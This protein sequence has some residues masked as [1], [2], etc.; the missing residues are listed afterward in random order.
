MTSTR[1][2]GNG[3]AVKWA[4]FVIKYRWLVLL[5]SIVLA[6]GMGSGG[7]KIEFDSDYHVFFGPDNPQMLTFDALQDKYTKD[8][9]VFIVFEPTDGTV[10]TQATLGAIEEFVDSSWMTPFSTR[11]DAI[12]NFQHTRA[13]EDDLYVDD[14]V[15]DAETL[16]QSRLD[17]VR[18]I[19]IHE[20]LLK[21]RLISKDGSVTAVNITVKLPGEEITE[22]AD[23]IAFVRDQIAKFE[24][25][26]PGINTYES[27]MIMMSGAFFESSQKDLST[28]IPLMFLVIILTILLLTRNISATFSTVV[29]IF[30]SIIAAM[31]MAGWLGIRL[32]PPSAS[33]PTIITTLAVADSIH[34]LITMLQ[35]MR[36]GMDK[37]S[38]I[39]ESMRLNF[40][41]VFI[42]SFTTIIGFLTMNFSD[43]PPFGDLG[44][45]TSIGMA[46]AF[47]FS[48]TILPAL[49]TI[50]PVRVKVRNGAAEE[51]R[52]IYD[53]L[54]DWVIL[55]NKKVMWGT[56]IAILGISA[57]TLRNDLNDE[58]L[59]YFDKS[60][61]F[62]SDT[63]F[64]SENL[65]GI[66][67]VEYSLAAAES[68]GINEP[69]YLADLQ[70][71]EQW[72]YE[73]PEVI[74]VNSFVE[75]AR[76][77]NKSM[78]GDSLKYYTPPA[79]R[80]EAAQYLL[81]YEMSLPFG[82][83]L[84]NQIN[85]DKSETRLTTTI[86]NVSSS[87]LIAFKER[88]ENWLKAN[89]PSH[90]HTEGTSTTVVFSYLT[91][92]Q[93]NSMM[94][95]SLL[96][97][98]L[99]SIILAIALKSPK[100]GVLSLIPNVTPILVGFGIWG[101][102]VGMIN[103]GNAIVF[104]MTLGIIVDDTVHFLSKYLRARREQGKSP[105]EAVRYAFH[106]VGQA[107]VVTTIVLTAGF[108]ILA[109]SS[110]GLNSGMAKLT[111]L[112]IV[113]ALIID[114]LL[115]PAMLI[116]LGRKTSPSA[117]NTGAEDVQIQPA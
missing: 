95:G 21:D 102:A 64:I 61:S 80:D 93:I 91:G 88:S 9:N 24:E 69:S 58:F 48:V 117:T 108:A 46:M 66:Y 4:N 96:A 34:V 36:R 11:V 110:F 40:M 78:H 47:L 12:T 15:S 94:K 18:E 99:I 83:D 104:G 105:E 73:Q 56:A 77:V 38:A 29:V 86:E 82:L 16:S 70:N 57:L 17:S 112:I 116:R 90:M 60:I 5:G 10:F 1:Q 84:N 28:L 87:E 72:L 44:N 35:N 109:Q 14:L 27:G 51:R 65:T 100:Y 3:L 13:V 41:P 103:S 39:I 59:K 97:L 81:L 63:D 76:R 23:V 32:T 107:L 55:H 45:I 2:N 37:R 79:S 92:R 85:V 101:L 111:A 33:A 25:K 115:L 89:T 52:S 62:R 98:L 7:Q 54:A 30:L 106:T 43:V 53:R 22:G 19:A 26:Y 20:P 68:G 113:I 49:M 8:D 50:L 6:M 71:F 74:H 114:F 75:V 42:T 67:N 31:G